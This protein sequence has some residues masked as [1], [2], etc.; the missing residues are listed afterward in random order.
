MKQPNH[1]HVAEGN[2]PAESE[3]AGHLHGLIDYLSCK[4]SVS[5]EFLFETIEDLFKRSNRWDLVGK[6]EERAMKRRGLSEANVKEALGYLDPLERDLSA[7]LELA[8][9][10]EEQAAFFEA[11]LDAWRS[12]RYVRRELDPTA[13]DLYASSAERRERREQDIDTS[14]NVNIGAN[15]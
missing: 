10:P 3:L 13:W 1:S 2:H 4:E 5:A 8:T 15:S 12:A 6:L 11:I 9:I 7:A 14:D